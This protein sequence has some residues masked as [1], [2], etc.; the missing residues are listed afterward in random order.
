[1]ITGSSRAINMQQPLSFLSTKT[2]LITKQFYI[3]E[4]NMSAISRLAAL[5]RG[6]TRYGMS[7][8][9]SLGNLGLL[10]NLIIFTQPAHRRNPCALYICAVSVCS[11]VGMNIALVPSIYALDHPNPVTSSLAFCRTHFYLLHVFNQSMRTFIVI[12]CADRYAS[13][14]RQAN[15]RSWS[16]YR[17]TVR[18][19]PAVM[20]FW[21]L[22]AVFPMMLR[23]LVNGACDVRL[24]TPS[25][26]Y[27]IYMLTVLSLFPLTSMIT[28]GVL[29]IRSL[30]QIRMR[31]VPISDTDVSTTA[32]TLR[33]RDRD[34]MTMLAIE[35]FL[36]VITTIPVT[37]ALV[38]K[39]TTES[40]V[41]SSKRRDIESFVLYVTRLFLLYLNNSLSFWI[42]VSTSKS[43]RLECRNLLVKWSNFVACDIPYRNER[44]H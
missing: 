34:L 23:S 19:I 30:K 42:Y 13:C 28:F 25:T 18:V 40:H 7:T 44:M 27:T 37:I 17:I 2:S 4:V 12:A 32:P 11:L 36:Y 43:F 38:Y 21:T 14:S 33:K 6:L 41:K 10:F 29:M 35:L 15:I 8:Y 39:T 20:L 31:V 9:I 5:Q 24:G 16:R 26:I 1:M 22:L 3:D